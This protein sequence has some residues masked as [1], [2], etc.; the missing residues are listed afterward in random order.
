LQIRI[1]TQH[2][3]CQ[4][5]VNS[6][7]KKAASGNVRI[8]IEERTLRIS[9]LV[10]PASSSAIKA[11]HTDDRMPHPPPSSLSPPVNT[12]NPREFAQGGWVV[13]SVWD[14]SASQ[15]FSPEYLRFFAR[16]MVFRCMR[17]LAHL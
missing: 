6:G 14:L 4:Q 16:M 12:P 1:A 2:H 8:A 7:P 15:D 10:L 9:G 11:D 13:V 5:A 3:E 17:P